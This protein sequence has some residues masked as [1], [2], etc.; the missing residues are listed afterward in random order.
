MANL[1]SWQPQQRNPFGNGRMQSRVSGVQLALQL[2]QMDISLPADIELQTCRVT[3]T[4]DVAH[5]ST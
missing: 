2:W 1:I 5:V 3:S 4:L